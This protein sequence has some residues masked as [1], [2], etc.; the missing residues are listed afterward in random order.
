M[1]IYCFGNEYIKEDSMAKILVEELSYPGV[2]FVKSNNPED[3]MNESGR[4]IILDVVKDINEVMLIENL[5]QLK[6]RN[7]VSLHDFDLSFFL[8]LMQQMGK[9][10]NIKIIGIP[11]FGD[12]DKIKEGIMTKLNELT[13][14]H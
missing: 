7:M 5:D 9:I 11:Q 8:K 1:N 6:V 10:I 2:K 4:I 12:K 13:P 14:F 3:I